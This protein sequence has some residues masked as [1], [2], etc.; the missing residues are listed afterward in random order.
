MFKKKS[1]LILTLFFTFLMACSPQFVEETAEVDQAV[2]EDALKPVV[3]EDKIAEE[4]EVV[5]DPDSY[6]APEAETTEEDSATEAEEVSLAEGYPEPE[7][8]VVEETT[9]EEVVVSDLRKLPAL[10]AS[11]S[12]SGGAPG[13][14]GGGG[15]AIAESGAISAAGDMVESSMMI[16]PVAMFAETQFVLAGDFP[17]TPDTLQVIERMRRPMTA[18][19][20]LE[21]MQ[22]N[23][24]AGPLYQEQLSLDM[25]E[26]ME[27]AEDGSFRGMPFVGFDEERQITLMNGSL[28]IDTMANVVRE[29]FDL[30]QTYPEAELIALT[31][32]KIAELNVDFEY[33]LVVEP[34]GN[35]LVFPIY[36]GLT[37]KQPVM[38]MYFDFNGNGEPFI[39]STF[40]DVYAES[41]V[42]GDYPLLT[43]EAAWANLMPS[44]AD[45][46]AFWNFDGGFFPIDPIANDVEVDEPQVWLAQ[47][48]A[49][50]SANLYGY[51]LIY[52]PVADDSLP[53]IFVN[54]MRI[55]APAEVGMLVATS[56]EGVF[57]IFGSYRDHGSGQLTFVADGARSIPYSSQLFVQGTVSRDGDNV[58]ID[59]EANGRLQLL[60]APADLPEGLQLFADGFQV[61]E[62]EAGMPL[63]DWQYM[64]EFVDYGF[65]DD[66]VISLDIAP[67]PV[68]G[69]G[70]GDIDLSQVTIEAAEFGYGVS[71]PQYNEAEDMYA[72]IQSNYLI[73]VWTFSGVTADGSAISFEIP[74]VD[75]S[76]FQN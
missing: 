44:L 4:V 72:P 67:I 41:T 49:G 19:L 75:S 28:W 40:L 58:Y 16:D 22:Q 61:G 66:E 38:G 46:A 31:E 62:T 50:Q 54:G 1:I 52:N 27:I 24:F 14:V 25:I 5:K 59:S 51:P 9:A 48:V 29:E 8:P 26:E 7:A 23:G 6:P 10:A 32:A 33:E 56:P 12:G 70:Y 3:N 71:W 11:G 43:A 18:E 65:E 37:I 47:G 34:F 63:F 53:I 57:Q 60:N 39:R 2:V 64:S 35:V 74:A 68:D 21:L 13:P 76:Y 15:E 42:V 17:V 55:E 45:G 30:S 73:P 69:M 20:A 36:N